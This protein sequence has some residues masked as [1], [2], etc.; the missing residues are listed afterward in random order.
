MQETAMSSMDMLDVGQAQ[1]FKLACRRNGFTP[2]DLKRLCEGD[3][4]AR[5]R[6][7]LLGNLTITAPHVIDC[8]APPFVPDGFVVETHRKGGLIEWDPKRVQLWCS[9]Q[10][11]HSY[12]N[13]EDLLDELRDK[14]VLNAN[15]LDYLLAHPRLIPKQEWS[16][17]SVHSVLFWGTTYRHTNGRR[18]V[19]AIEWFGDSIGWKSSLGWIEGYPLTYCKPAAILA[20]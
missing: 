9:E 5:V 2:E 6:D 16:N 13:G 19:R 18:N 1:E 7:V 17:L 3:T 10:Q 15:V 8:D 11:A 4:L 20:N 12:I 14:P